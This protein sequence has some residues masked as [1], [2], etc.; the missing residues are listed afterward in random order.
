MQ[1]I[2]RDLSPLSKKQHGNEPVNEPCVTLATRQ[3]VS[4]DWEFE[5]MIMCNTV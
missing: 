3:K 4:S 5:I 2:H 1:M